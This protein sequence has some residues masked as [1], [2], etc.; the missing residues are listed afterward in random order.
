[1]ARIPSLLVLH[2]VGAL[3]NERGACLTTPAAQ[4]LLVTS[5]QLSQKRGELM[6]WLKHGRFEDDMAFLARKERGRGGR[7]QYADV[8]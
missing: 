4:R 2:S 6:A 1:M 3:F 5:W 7:A 8:W